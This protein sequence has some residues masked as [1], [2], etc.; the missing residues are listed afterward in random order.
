VRFASDPVEREIQ[1]LQDENERLRAA[2]EQLATGLI[3]SFTSRRIARDA[4][5]AVSRT[6]K[7]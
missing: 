7:P 6:E 4:L 2:L 5:A 3:G 1:R